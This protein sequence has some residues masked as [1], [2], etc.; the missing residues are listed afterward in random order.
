MLLGC[1][2]N[3]I[4]RSMNGGYSWS[5]RNPHPEATWYENAN[6]F[7]YHIAFHPENSQIVLASVG[8]SNNKP[9]NG[10]EGGLLMNSS[11]GAGGSN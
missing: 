8:T 1:G 9:R 11:T 10:G 5:L 2:D 3:G 6:Q 7:V 4:L